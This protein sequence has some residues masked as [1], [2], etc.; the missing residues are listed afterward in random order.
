M[1]RL[2]YNKSKVL[3]F[4]FSLFYILHSQ[5]PFL[6]IRPYAAPSYEQYPISAQLD[7]QFPTSNIA[8]DVFFVLMVILLMAMSFTLIA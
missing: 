8:D 5:E 6:E 2:L 4:Y 3:K 1:L 7:H